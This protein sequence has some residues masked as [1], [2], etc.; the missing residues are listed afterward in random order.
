MKYNL[1]M[2]L[3]FLLTCNMHCSKVSSEPKSKLVYYDF[4]QYGMM[5]YPDKVYRVYLQPDGKTKLIHNFTNDREEIEIYVPTFVLDSIKCMMGKHKMYQYK[6][7]YTSSLSIMDGYTWS[8]TA[9]FEDQTEFSSNGNNKYPRGN[10]FQEIHD[11]L[12]TYINN[13][14]NE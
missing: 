14:E 7:H 12:D 9:R 2:A 10:G 5:S 8:Y 3:S 13:N 1:L 6:S 11:F 4:I